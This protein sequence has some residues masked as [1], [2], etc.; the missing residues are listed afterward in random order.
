MN[1]TID[2]KDTFLI[3]IILYNDTLVQ[4]DRINLALNWICSG[5]G[6]D[7]MMDSPIM[8]H[9]EADDVYTTV[10]WFRVLFK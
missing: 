9:G 8:L 2:N 6:N 1:G 5:N 7:V 3:C 4:C 10:D